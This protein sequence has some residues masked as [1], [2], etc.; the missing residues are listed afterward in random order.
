MAEPLELT[1]AAPNLQRVLTLCVDIGPGLMLGE[2]VDASFIGQVHYP[3]ASQVVI[4][5]YRF[6]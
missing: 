3:N 4:R 1:G 2:S 6:Y 5:C